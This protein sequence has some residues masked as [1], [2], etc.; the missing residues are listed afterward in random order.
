MSVNYEL[1]LVF[2]LFD[3]GQYF[4]LTILLACVHNNKEFCGAP[5]TRLFS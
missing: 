3:P 1:A 5:E 4:I 2:P